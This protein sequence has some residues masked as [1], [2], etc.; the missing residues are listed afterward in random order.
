M[1]ALENIRLDLMPNTPVGARERRTNSMPNESKTPETDRGAAGK[2][3]YCFK[4][5]KG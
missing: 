2:A 3:Y 1:N 5:T 4:E